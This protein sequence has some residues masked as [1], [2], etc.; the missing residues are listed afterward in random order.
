MLVFGVFVG[1]GPPCRGLGNFGHWV[2]RKR[3]EK[4]KIFIDNKHPRLDDVTKNVIE[5]KYTKL[6]KTFFNGIFFQSKIGPK[7]ENW[8][9]IRRS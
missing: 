4:K 7:L 2:G 6:F 9:Q 1:L 5:A 8:F 3:K